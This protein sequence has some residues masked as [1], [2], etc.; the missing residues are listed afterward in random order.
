MINTK[1]HIEHWKNGSDED[2]EVAQQLI[3]SNKIRHGLFFLHLSMEKLL[4]AHI[5]SYTNDIAPKLHNLIRLSELSGI[6]F[7]PERTDFLS[8]MNPF[9]IEGRYPELW[10]QVPSQKEAEELLQKAEE[11][12]QCLN[13]QL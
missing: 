2:F 8:E 3:R 5:C 9:N 12:L 13:N 1:K 6:T 4:K 11:I 7:E 10:G